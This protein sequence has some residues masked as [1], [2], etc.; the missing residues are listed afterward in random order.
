MKVIMQILGIFVIFIHKLWKILNENI[1]IYLD[2]YYIFLC[3]FTHPIYIYIC[4]CVCVCMCV[5]VCVCVCA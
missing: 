5:C 1:R 4:V 2:E 3:I